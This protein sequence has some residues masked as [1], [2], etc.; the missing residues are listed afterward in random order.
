MRFLK[1]YDDTH[2]TWIWTGIRKCIFCM[3]RCLMSYPWREKIWY[4]KRISSPPLPWI[5]TKPVNSSWFHSILA[6]CHASELTGSW[7][8]QK[9]DRICVYSVSFQVAK[10]L[11]IWITRLVTISVTS[12]EI[13]AVLTSWIP[14]LFFRLDSLFFCAANEAHWGELNSSGRKKIGRKLET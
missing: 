12:S 2:V 14:T 13:H 1:F 5:S 7:P 8:I 10:T 11:L 6:F 9:T 4:W 3:A